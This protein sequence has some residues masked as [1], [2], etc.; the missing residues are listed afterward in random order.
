MGFEIPG[1]KLGTRW[2][3]PR[4]RTATGSPRSTPA[5]R[6]H[7]VSAAGGKA[8]GVIQSPAVSGEAVELTITGVSKVEAG[9][10]IAN[11]PDHE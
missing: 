9:A 2:Q 7:S 5:A 4:W 8:V 3:P 11:P 10:A 1:F 6:W